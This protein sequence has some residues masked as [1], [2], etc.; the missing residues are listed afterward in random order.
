MRLE[1]LHRGVDCIEDRVARQTGLVDEIALVT[2][3]WVHE[4]ADRWVWVDESIA[5][6]E[7]EN[8]VTRDVVL[9]EGIKL[10]ICAD[11]RSL[12]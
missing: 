10:A 7:D 8:L 3:M 5:L 2:E 11:I 6:R 12:S 9:T 1:A 4:G